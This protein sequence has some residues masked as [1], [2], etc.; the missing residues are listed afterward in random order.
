MN[1]EELK[2]R[3]LKIIREEG[4]MQKYLAKHIGICETLLSRFKNGKAELGLIDSKALDSYL[5]S[6]GY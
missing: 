2:D 5:Q 1:Q 3:L 6:K 4:V